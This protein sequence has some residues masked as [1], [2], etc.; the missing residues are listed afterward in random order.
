MIA[1]NNSF[2]NTNLGKIASNLNSSKE[3]IAKILPKFIL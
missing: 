3:K 2:L 1:M